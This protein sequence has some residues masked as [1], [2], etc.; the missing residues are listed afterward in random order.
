MMNR[1]K[2]FMVAA[3]AFM[4]AITQSVLTNTYA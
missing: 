1:N 2:L 4:I 3:L